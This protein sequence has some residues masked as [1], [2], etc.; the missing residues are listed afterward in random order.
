MHIAHYLRL[1]ATHSKHRCTTR[2]VNIIT[3]QN[4]QQRLYDSLTKSTMRAELSTDQTSKTGTV[5]P[6]GRSTGALVYI[7]IGAIT[8]NNHKNQLVRDWN[9]WQILQ[10]GR[11]I[12]TTGSTGIQIVTIFLSH[13]VMPVGFSQYW[14]TE[15]RPKFRLKVL[16]QI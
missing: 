10:T 12:S 15:T 7:H 11:A 14:I 9:H 16:E 6:T 1:W 2:W 8:Q 5:V 13:C 3:I 4:V